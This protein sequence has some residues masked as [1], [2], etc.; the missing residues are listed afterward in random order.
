MKSYKD[1][2]DEIDMD[3]EERFY[4]CLAYHAIKHDI[5]AEEIENRIRI[6]KED[7]WLYFLLFHV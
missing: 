3:D 1:E 2:Y 6:L 5:N 7:E 4:A